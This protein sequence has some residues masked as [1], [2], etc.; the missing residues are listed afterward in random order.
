MKHI[1]AIALKDIQETMRDRL[2]FMFL[3]AMPVIFTLLFGFAFDGG[4]PAADTRP[5][6]G[7]LDQDGSRLSAALKDFLLASGAVR[8]DETQGLTAAGLEKL[9]ADDKL[10]AS[11]FRAK[12]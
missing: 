1:L 4:T 5:V 11:P 3:L 6:V 12:A 7:W 9:V 10:A 8:L 2:T